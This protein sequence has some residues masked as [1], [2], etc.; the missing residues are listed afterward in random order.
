MNNTIPGSMKDG[1]NH[2][3]L[4]IGDKD[5]DRIIAVATSSVFDDAS[6]TRIFWKIE[7]TSMD[8]GFQGHL[9]S[10]TSYSS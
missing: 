2:L 8:S 5:Q 9:Y 7:N 10:G 3:G 1:V 4:I 6:L